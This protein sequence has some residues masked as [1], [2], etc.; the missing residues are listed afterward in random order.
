MDRLES[1]KKKIEHNLE[2]SC[3]EETYDLTEDTAYLLQRL[4]RYEKA[5][6]DIAFG[7]VEGG[8]SDVKYFAR[9]SLN[10]E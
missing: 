10:E 1:I 5:L 9:E 3:W 7:R 4:E 6:Q 2:E 8:Y